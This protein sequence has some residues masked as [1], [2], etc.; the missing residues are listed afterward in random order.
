MV[1]VKNLGQV[2]CANEAAVMPS[3]QARKYIALSS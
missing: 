1:G 2:L 3:Q